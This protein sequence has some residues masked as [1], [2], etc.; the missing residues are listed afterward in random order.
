VFL[1][2]GLAAA[3]AV[4]ALGRDRLRSVLVAGAALGGAGVALM[5][6]RVLERRIVGA[7][8]PNPGQIV[9]LGADGS[10]QRIIDGFYATVLRVSYGSGTAAALQALALV[11]ITV[12][13]IYLMRS[14]T[15][16][17]LVAALLL[18]ARA[19]LAVR[20]V[21]LPADGVPGLLAAFPLAVLGLFAAARNRVRLD[22]RRTVAMTVAV[23]LVG[24][25]ATQ[26]AVGGGVE[27]GGR[28]FALAVPLVAPFA[29]GGL[30][31][32][33]ASFTGTSRTVAGAG[34][35]L[36]V[37]AMAL[38][39]VRALSA[40]E[41]AADR[42]LARLPAPT[43][44][45]SSRPVVVTTALPVPRF[46]GRDFAE[47]RWLL[48]DAASPQGLVERLRGAGIEQFVFLTRNIDAEPTVV[49]GAR[50]VRS[51]ESGGWQYLVY[52]T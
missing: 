46:A 31:A 43:A 38:L 48:V 12:V 4:R 7:S 52:A 13:G 10:V 42:V 29:A 8:V 50:L 28:Y 24:V 41:R 32:A 33:R 20:A 39:G 40:R 30:L 36:I 19:I 11:L 5:A 9:P 16:T 34:L 14:R 2:V 51:H 23:Y 15:E 47:H 27:W 18:G 3:M 21:T 49:E 37:L 25:V 44:E 17:A 35:A 22:A 26:Y 45:L 6:D 1:A